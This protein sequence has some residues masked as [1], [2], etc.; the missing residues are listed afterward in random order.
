[1]ARNHRF[2]PGEWYHCYNRGVEKR[3]TFLSAT[4]YHR[5]M[6]L[7]YTCNSSEPY[8]NLTY[9]N[10]SLADAIERQ[11][12]TG[13]PLVAIGVYCMMPNHFHFLM[14]E[15]V[16]GGIA[17]FMQKAI[18]G[19]TMYFNKKYERS[20]P[21]FVAGVFKSRHVDAD[22]YLQHVA[23][24][25]HLNPTDLK[26]KWP[27][28]LTFPYSSLADFDKTTHRIQKSLLDDEI[29]TLINQDLMHN[30][31]KEAAGVYATKLESP[32]SKPRDF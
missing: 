24:Y 28:V 7:M 17:K 5:F 4:D 27:E 1:M 15:V 11:G 32:E 19:Y 26:L 22:V 18:T 2:A 14:K 30:S 12:R 10:E 31:L 25:I 9:R 23:S 20:G 13:T 16:E 8:E 21:L 3:T 29:F 6:L